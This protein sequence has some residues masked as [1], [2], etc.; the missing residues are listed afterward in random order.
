MS[1]FQELLGRELAPSDR[2]SIESLNDLPAELLAEASDLAKKSWP[3][4]V[5]YLEFYVRRRDEVMDF[6]EEVL[7]G[8]ANA[9]TW[10]IRDVVCYPRLE[11]SALCHITVREYVESLRSVEGERWYRIAVEAQTTYSDDLGAPGVLVR[12][13]RYWWRPSG[14]EVG[15]AST[16]GRQ[17][18]YLPD[19]AL[20]IAI[21]RWIASRLAWYFDKLILAGST[22]WSQLLAAAQEAAAGVSGDAALALRGLSRELRAYPTV[23]KSLGFRGPDDF[24]E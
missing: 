19:G 13:A 22:D 16:A 9:A 20:P 2:G 6:V 14:D 17:I 21:R 4:A 23:T 7:V 18:E 8:G 24:Y 3:A 12:D 11:L 1:F 5:R 10:R 15:F